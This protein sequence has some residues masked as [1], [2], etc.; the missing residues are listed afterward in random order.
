[1]TMPIN[2]PHIY[3]KNKLNIRL[4]KKKM[5]NVCSVR[6]MAGQIPKGKK[7]VIL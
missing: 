4:S 2:L 7:T 3:W 1:M 6:S 5:G